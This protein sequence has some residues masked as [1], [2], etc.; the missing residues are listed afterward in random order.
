MNRLSLKIFLQLI[1][2][3]LA[4]LTI[5]WGGLFLSMILSSWMIW[6]AWDPLYQFLKL[7]ERNVVPVMLILTVGGVLFILYRYWMKTMGY[8][9]ALIEASSVLMDHREETQVV[10]PDELE[11]VER[12]MNGLKVDFLRSERAAKEA[13]QRKNDLIVYL[14]H[15]LKTPLTSVIGYLSLLNDEPQISMPLRQKYLKIAETKAERLEELIN[16][17]FEITRFNL[18]TLTLEAEPV[19]LTR[20]LEQIVWEFKPMADEKKIAFD[21][22]IEPGM[23]GMLDINKIERVFDNLLR[24]AI[25]YGYTGGT[26]RIEACCQKDGFHLCFENQGPTI[27]PQKLERIFEQFY[28][29]DSSRGTQ[30]G[31]AGLGLAIAREIITLHHGTIEAQSEEEKIRFLVFI[32]QPL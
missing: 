4:Y 26:L 6:Y 3:E 17:F 19:N 27:P 31:G 9:E 32:P 15:D 5:L 25:S 23:H 28:R 16:E 18:T 22:Q 10:L 11:P 30:K 13:E 29:L 20:M 24:N 2:A 8:V 21:L 7:L 1:L 14:A 12:Q